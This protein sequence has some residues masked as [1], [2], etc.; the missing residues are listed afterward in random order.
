MAT[1]ISDAGADE[2]LA[3]RHAPRLLSIVVS[4][5]VAV[6][7]VVMLCAVACGGSSMGHEP[8]GSLVFTSNRGSG[9]W[10]AYV[11]NAAGTATRRLVRVQ[12]PDEYCPSVV[13]WSRDGEHLAYASVSGVR[14]YDARTGRA[15][16]LYPG[17]DACA[18]YSLSPNGTK[19]AYEDLNNG[20][21]VVG[22]R[23]QS[24][25][26][27]V[28]DSFGM[29]WS[30]D[31]TQIAYVNNNSSGF[32][33]DDLEVVSGG[34][35]TVVARN[36][37]RAV[38]P[39]WSPDGRRLAYGAF[40]N[41]EEAA[42]LGVVDADGSHRLRLSG[43][44]GANL[45][46]D[47]SPDGKQLVFS[48]TQG[49]FVAD[50]DGTSLRRLAKGGLR[51]V[52]WSSDGRLIAYTA[53]SPTVAWVMNTD[54]SN[55]H[56]LSIDLPLGGDVTNVSWNPAGIPVQAIA[57][58]AIR[59][60]RSQLGESTGPI[61]VFS[62]LTGK[63]VQSF[64]TFSGGG[65]DAIVADGAGGWFIGGSFTRVGGTQCAR[66][67]HINA[68]FRLDRRFCG[69]PDGDVQALAVRGTNLYLGGLFGRLAGANRPSFGALD[70]RSGAA[71]AWQPLRD[72]AP[73]VGRI[74]LATLGRSVYLLGPFWGVGGANR[75]QL[76]AVDAVSGAVQP[77]APKIPL[78]QV[79]GHYDTTLEQLV[80]STGAVYV[81]GFDLVEALNTRSG[82]PVA[83][84]SWPWSFS[85][86]L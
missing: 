54:G 48:D 12:E 38:E 14:V 36:V 67:A 78:A 65:V 42:F 2:H 85:G 80:P 49:T 43:H 6:G 50:A 61:A 18:H 84:C 58:T 10:A 82:A 77:W 63:R 5:I 7:S 3:S 40:P 35:L 33:P 74:G 57:G 19:L 60:P 9:G 1:Q 52:S 73:E 30:P 45:V 32:I 11:T 46:I 34:N 86:V 16:N 25:A 22:V 64:P 27:A 29:A 26:V 79:G 66:L 53:G 44:R 39:V 23:G 56:P 8:K 37:S 20:L 15:R 41:D 75:Q 47:W 51:S 83:C 28:G 4:R 70:M 21:R 17:G 59:I 69:K 31:G 13:R 24:S 81:D 76:A 71:V 72:Q 68:S 62:A 55:A